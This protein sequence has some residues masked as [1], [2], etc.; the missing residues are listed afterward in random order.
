MKCENCEYSYYEN[1]GEDGCESMCSVFGY[2]PPDNLQR[3]DGQGCIYNRQTL[4]KIKR[5]NDVA[6]MKFLIADYGRFVE[7][8]NKNIKEN[9]Q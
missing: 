9:K 8:Y 5:Q 3:T 4:A 7:W 1:Y 6:E 2:E